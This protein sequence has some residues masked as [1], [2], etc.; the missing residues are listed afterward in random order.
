MAKDEKV[1]KPIKRAFY[2][3]NCYGVRVIYK[4]RLRTKETKERKRKIMLNKNTLLFFDITANMILD[5]KNIITSIERMRSIALFISESGVTP[6]Y[7]ATVVLN[8]GTMVPTI[9]KTRV[10]SKNFLFFLNSSRA[11]MS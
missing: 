5:T 3:R 6:P 1:G 9:P 10:R 2:G 7:L 4:I 8:Q 11:L